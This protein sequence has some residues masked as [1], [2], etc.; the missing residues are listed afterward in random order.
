[1]RLPV[2]TLVAGMLALATAT[3]VGAATVLAI[4]GPAEP[5]T[6]QRPAPPPAIGA[7]RDGGAPR[8]DP[9]IEE[10]LGGELPRLVVAGAQTA[11]RGA[12]ADADRVQRLAALRAEPAFAA[13][14]PGLARAWRAML[15]SL[16]PWLALTAADPEWPT[17]ARELRARAEVVSDQ[18]AAAN[19]GYYL[20]PSLV[21]D[22]PRRRTGIFTYRIEHVAFVRAND[23][24]IRVLDARRLDRLDAG[25]T[26]LGIKAEELDDPV[27]L[28]DA[29]EAKVETQILP[30]LAG[31]A[32]PLGDDAWAAS[33]RGR[34]AARA[35][36]DAIRRELLSA[37]YTDVGSTERAM[38][39]C[40]A[41]LVASVRH[42]EAQHRL[43]Q[44][45]GLTH[46]DVLARRLGDRPTEPFA[47]RTRYELSAYLSQLA[48]DVWLPQLTLWNLARHGFRR[49]HTRTEEALVAVFAI[50]GLAR[51][52]G[53]GAGAEVLRNGEIDRDRLAALATALSTRTTVEL[54]AAAAGLWAE[55]Y[56]R[57]LV[58]L[59]D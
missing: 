34:A 28:L 14:G 53:V 55:L 44:D 22:H 41:L 7:F 31:R 21:A 42:H 18:L 59:H 25:A 43:D 2:A 27:V 57:P 50:E 35:A 4:Q 24:R 8:H 58:R 17:A 20:E 19:L 51:R 26:L 30:M 52:L 37:L 46:P 13:H 29:V 10:V 1:M 56:G 3:T 9:A 48:S 45:R 15:T 12:L 49:S 5:A 32:F 11:G 38:A 47:L 54:R 16:E 36:G 33:P 39:R 40:R 23:Q 6:Y